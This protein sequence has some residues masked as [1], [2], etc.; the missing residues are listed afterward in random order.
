MKNRYIL[1]LLVLISCSQK[2]KEKEETVVKAQ[3]AVAESIDS[4]KEVSP[5]SFNKI[6][7]EIKT[8]ST[9]LIDAT[10]FDS[11]ID[12]DDY[13]K[14]DVKA[15]KLENIYP[16]FNKEGHHYRAIA[17]YRVKISGEFHSIVVTILKGDHE[18][19]S[20]L[21]NYD[22][23][24]NI[25][26]SKVISYDEIAE[27]QSRIESKIEENEL[28]INNILWIDEK[29]VET[30]SFQ[31]KAN[32]KIEP[33]S[34][35]ENLIDSA[36]QQLNLEISKVNI[37]LLVTKVM[38]N[39]PQET[40]IVIPE[41]VDDHND[42][43]HFELNS[44]IIVVNSITGK[45][46]HKYFESSETNGWVSDAIE[47]SEIAIDTAPYI[48]AKDTRAFGIR[49]YHYGRSKPNPYSNRTIS[50]FIKSGDT[51][52]KVLD[53]YDVEDY[54][55]EWDTQ[56]AGES[57]SVK[58]TLIMSEEKTNAYFDII[59]KSKVL[60]SKTFVDENGECDEESKTSSKTTVLQFNGKEYVKNKS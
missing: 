6:I 55:G 7:S 33:I 30:T 54:G 27:G 45:I 10:N 34:Q 3:D 31:I 23:E 50:L 32:G 47:L 53:N 44:H 28:T 11:F 12:E 8:K 46:T 5:I 21:I 22:L 2:A 49:V 35:E 37:D 40:I 56:C 39:N 52:K 41:Y 18:M 59:V 13:K 17:S 38:P 43:Y 15:L 25:I 36:I 26:D 29:K 4:T 20:V 16:D 1:V 42:E 19:E 58:N 60:E 48:V 57:T 51:L 14:V 9:P 24:G